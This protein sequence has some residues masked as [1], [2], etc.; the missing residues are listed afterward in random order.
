MK[1]VI[2]LILLYLIC[3]P[4]FADSINPYVYKTMTNQSYRN[5]YNRQVN[6]KTIPYWQRQSNF[7]TR[8]RGYTNYSGYN[9]FN[10]YHSQRYYRGGRY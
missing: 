4:V 1:K 9:N 10:S 8:S 2:S 6:N 7:A 3:S 5:N